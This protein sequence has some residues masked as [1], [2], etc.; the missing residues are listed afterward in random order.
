MLNIG[1]ADSSATAADSPKGNAQGDPL[2][3]RPGKNWAEYGAEF[4]GTMLL[5]FGGLSA[6]VLDFS[7]GTPMAGLIPG[8]SPRLLL[9]GLL[10]AGTGSL[11]AISPLGR[12][13][14]AHI[15]PSVSLGFFVHGKMHFRDFF[16]YVISQFGGAIVGAF[17]LH[18]VWGEHAASVKDGMTVPGV[19][20]Y[21]VP[22][23][24]AAE[25]ALTGLMVLLIFIFVSSKRLMRWTPLMNWLLIA[26]MVW[27]EA[28]ISGTSLNPARS[29]GP[30]LIYGCWH[31]QWLY[32]IAPPLGA[33]CAVGLY[34][35]LARGKHDIRTCKLFHLADDTSIFRNVV[36]PSRPS[37]PSGN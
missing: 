20:T 6:V 29:I 24:F 2:G 18:L 16:A 30:A 19:P 12:R 36:E 23:A 13:S 32:C 33:I 21:T 28:P 7:N 1:A 35:L 15:N 8:K 9:T 26:T 25:M 31:D 17:L 5:V 22:E 14:G 10:F 4:L 27:Q 34:R 37:S 3:I 11:I